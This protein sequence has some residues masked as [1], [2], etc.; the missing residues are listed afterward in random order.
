MSMLIDP[1]R[2]GSS[3]SGT[4]YR[5]WRLG[6]TSWMTPS[7]AGNSGLCRVAELQLITPDT[8][9]HPTAAMTGNSAPS[10]LVA[11]A[12]SDLGSGFEAFRAFDGVLSDS[13]R[14]ISASVTTTDQWV[15]IDLG[16]GNEIRPTTAKVAPDGGSNVDPNGNYMIDF[17]IKGS[18]TGSFAGE[19]VTFLTVT[20]L[21][22]SDWNPNILKTFTL[23]D[24]P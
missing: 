10:P 12:S 2:Y 14:W 22:R 18:N 19:E 6:C 3:G 21:L 8:T 9:V 4:E 16:A 7:G 23:L 15:Q 5:Y 1:Y 24:P 11:S 13:G 17:T 20:G